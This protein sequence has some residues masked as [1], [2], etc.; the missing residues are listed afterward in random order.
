MTQ[1]HTILVTGATG[2]LGRHLC[3]ILRQRFG[4]DQVIALSS[5]QADLTDPKAADRLFAH[6]RPSIV[7][8]LAAYSGGIGANVRHPADFFHRNILLM[9]IPFDAAARHGARRFLYPMGGCSYP[10][11]ARSPITESSMWKGYPQPESAPYSVAKMAGITAADA[12]RRQYGMETTVLIP[13]NMY[14]EYDNYRTE[15]AHVIP[16][17]IRRF[18]EATLSGAKEVTLWG[19]GSPTRDFVYA[20]DVAALFPHF[21]DHPSEHGPVNLSTGHSTSIRELAELV[22]HE[23]GFQ[24]Q[25]LWDTS[26]PDGQSIKI[27]STEKLASLGLQC[28]TR[29]QDGLRRTIRWFREHYAAKTDGIRL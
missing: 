16:A 13:G 26:K 21:I 18:H 5:R 19:S 14:G 10:A 7:I 23:I 27:F 12:Y 29:L 15:D 9:A 6:H 25:I 2:F 22:A 4:E 11:D 20:G 28:P 24:G 3:P 1:T 8:H 17:L